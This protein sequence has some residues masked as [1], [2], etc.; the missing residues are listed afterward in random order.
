MTLLFTLLGLL[1]TAES[2]LAVPRF[3]STPVTAVN[4]DASYRYDISTADT[5]SG[6]RQVTAPTLPSWLSLTNVNTGNGTARITG[7]PTQAQVGTHP[8]SLL[9]RNLSTNSTATQ[10]FS[11]VVANVNDAPVITGQSPNP[12]PLQ[13]GA[14]L[15]VTF[16][17]LLVTDVDNSYPT[18]FTLT[19]LNGTNYNR[20]GNTITPVANFTGTLTVPVR[21][22]DG[23]AN[24]S[25]FNLAV[26]VVPS[27]S[28]L[29]LGIAA[30]PTPALVGA[31]V[32]WRF[33][34][35]NSGPQSSTAA[36]LTAEFIGNPFG[37]T[38]LSSC[39]VTPVSDRQRLTCTVP[40][41]PGGTNAPVVVRGAA[42]Q[43]GDIFVI[44]GV[45]AQNDPSP[46][47]NSAETALHIAEILSAAPAQSL[48]TSDA[49]AAA[50]GDV[51]GDG[52]ADAVLVRGTA[53]SAAELYLNVVDRSNAA[54]RMLADLPLSIGDAVAASNLA[55][56]DVERDGD[57][58]L[59]TTSSTGGSNIL[60]TNTGGGAFVRS[61][62]L[63]GGQSHD[64]VAADF[65]GD[66]SSDL[67]FAN[68]GPNTVYLNRGASGFSRAADV[69]DGDSRDVAALD[70]DL[71]GLV[72]L[73]FAN[74]SG[75]S[76]F[77]RNLGAGA[78]APGVVVDNGGAHTVAAGDLN[79]DRRPDVVFGMRDDATGAPSRPVYQNNPGAGG[80]PLFVLLRRLGASPA[81]QVLTAD[82]DLDGALDVVSMNAT[83][84]HQIYRGDGAGGLALHP[85]QF[86]WD[87]TA[88]AALA[89]VNVDIGL[90]IV[91]AGAA[92]SA[93]FFDDGRGGFGLGDTTPP[94]IQMSGDAQT[95][96]TV[97]EPYVDAGAV[98]TDDLDGNI[99]PRIVSVNPV[100][101]SILGTYTVTYDVRDSSGNAAVQA[102]R[103]VQV[104]AREGVGGGGGGATHPLI[105]AILAMY[106]LGRRARRW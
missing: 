8:V 78:F 60:Y 38:E 103:T 28:D 53:G 54:R 4:E 51:N 1:S 63:G 42:A 5:Q 64:V 92:A 62:T 21:V 18:G 52:F 74:A 37:F 47:N 105:A 30:T 102:R 86:R 55:L 48:P 71:D 36:Q 32:E 11:V 13:P 88:G 100:N 83:G 70:F 3:T 101:T 69:G 65:D 14:S 91:V 97:G 29:S 73:V 31:T 104:T 46:A 41:I 59:V 2:A 106:L 27:N 39:S 40:T 93:V 76:R 9:V 90:D 98:A 16:T 19:V 50:T 58:D 26:S 96:V 56:F 34:I 95:T 49:T 75:P 24:S 66:G 68:T 85:V 6:H 89:K 33:T 45:V 61:A 43:D 20:N 87:G 35:A 57:L 81:L 44:A 82:V 22:N 10:T 72:D 67:V 12:I 23:T 7:T 77:H 25:N 84:T 94:V 17:H 80:S 99:T 15:T 79:G